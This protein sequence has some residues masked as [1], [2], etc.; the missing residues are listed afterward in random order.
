MKSEDVDQLVKTIWDYHHMNHKLEKADCIFVLGSH[1][2]R[3]AEH[4]AKLFLE[5]WAPIII[6]SGGIRRKNDLL[7]T[8]W[9]ESEA[10][11]FAKIAIKMGISKDKIIIENEATNTGENVLFTKKILKEKN[12][13]PKK[14][15]VVQ[16]PYMERR[17]YATIKKHWPEKIIILTSPPIDFERYPKKEIMKEDVIN[18]LVGDLQRIKIYPKKGFQIF[19]KIPE[20]VWNAYKKLVMLGYTKHLLT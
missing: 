18:I 14:I 7:K 5:A 19:Q 13:N 3:V 17:A 8:D 2:L 4:G 20:D 9:N 12:I 1:D 11:V 15:I 16:K 10:E 6:F